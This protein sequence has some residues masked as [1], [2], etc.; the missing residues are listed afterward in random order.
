MNP[1]PSPRA[2]L[3]GCF[4][5][6]RFVAKARQ[7]RDG[8]LSAEYAARFCDHDS[9]DD[10]FLRFFELPKT[11]LVDAAMR[12]HVDADLAA[13]F[14]ARPGIDAARIARWNELA[15]NLGRP[16]F[17]MAARLVEVLPRAYPHLDPAQ[18]ETIFALLEADEKP[19]GR[20]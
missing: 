4:W 5:L 18:V 3:A 20:T 9:V 15:V 14:C 12:L 8:E 6:P 10:H 13:W 11:E 1:L 7:W 19:A 2:E 16:G 17:P